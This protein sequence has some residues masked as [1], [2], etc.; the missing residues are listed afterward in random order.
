M[1]LERE[2]LKNICSKIVPAIS[3]S[4]INETSE[5]LELTVHNNVLTLY[6]SSDIYTLKIVEKLDSE[7]KDFTATIQAPTF[8]KLISQTTSEKIGLD[9]EGNALKVSG[10]GTYTFPLIYND[11][12][13]VSIPKYTV[14]VVTKE[15][16]I[17]N[18]I[19]QSILQY[20]SKYIDKKTF[21]SPLQRLYYVDGDGCL[22]FISGA[23]VNNFK[24]DNDLRILLDDRCVKLFSLFKNEDI[25]L[26]LGM[27]NN[28]SKTQT[29]VSLTTDDIKLTMILPED[30]SII[31]KFPCEAIRKLATTDYDNVV[32]LDSS[33]L[34]QSLNRLSLFRDT[35]NKAYLTF[36]FDTNNVSIQDINKENVET[37][38]YE[39]GSKIEK[40]YELIVDA[41]EFKQ[42]LSCVPNLYLSL[43]F[44]NGRSFMLQREGV[45][46][47][48]PECT[49]SL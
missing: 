44:G 45:T 19:L 42:A 41:D 21:N 46:I 13:L 33:K 12:V 4:D 37:I 1:L 49:R 35:N 28:N 20:N 27:R 8:L 15:F 3:H 23:C 29:V 47:I 6:V 7:T 40:P 30:M 17:K 39:D 43:S 16:N 34:Q 9:V 48:V 14:D 24:L 25:K 5:L 10:N 26:T 32:T 31:D 18:K 22:T 2:I 36:T 38:N 11:D